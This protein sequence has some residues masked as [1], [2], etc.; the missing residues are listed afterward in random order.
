MTVTIDWDALRAGLGTATL[1]YGTHL[2]AP[3]ARRWA[4][5]HVEFIPPAIIDPTRTPLHDPLRC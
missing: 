1:D 2:S 3:E 5:G 4:C